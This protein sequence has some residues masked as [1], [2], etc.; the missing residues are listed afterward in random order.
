MQD[1]MKRSLNKYAKNLK[2]NNEICSYE[3]QRWEKFFVKSKQS[4]NN[5]SL[6]YVSTYTNNYEGI[7]NTMANAFSYFDAYF[8]F[9][10][11]VT[12]NEINDKDLKSVL[13]G[14]INSAD[15]NE[16]VLKQSIQNDRLIIENKG[17]L[18]GIDIKSEYANNLFSMFSN[19]LLHRKDISIKGK[20]L[21]I[22]YLKEMITKG[23]KNAL[24]SPDEK[25]P[26]TNITINNWSGI[27]TTGDNEN[28]LIN[29]LD[30]TVTIEKVAIENTHSYFDTKVIISFIGIVV[31]LVVSFAFNF[32]IGTVIF[33]LSA[34][35]AIVGVFNITKAR[36]RVSKEYNDI[37]KNETEVL[38]NV[39][40]EIVDA[41]FSVKRCSSNYDYLINYINSFNESEL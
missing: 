36:D 11:L 27:T 12:D 41:Y 31:G 26:V 2:L 21:A 30:Q 34:F 8:S 23:M 17:D 25:F 6:P 7:S 32:A 18:E 22:S 37:K 15:R 33:V 14:L 3:E 1:I 4:V 24:S 10:K 5:E 39:L 38:E 35:M 20:R 16:S 13:L 19:I 9:E 40:A 28:D 29:S